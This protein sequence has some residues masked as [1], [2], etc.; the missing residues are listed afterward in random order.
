[1]KPAETSG[2]PAAP[3]IE[4]V[5]FV[6]ALAIYAA[7]RFAGLTR[8][9]IYFFCDEA[10]QGNLAWQRLHNGFRDHTGTFLPPYFL[11]DR[12]WAVS[13]SAYA[14]VLPALL[15]GKTVAAVRGPS[16]VV[17]ILGAAGAGVAGHIHMHALPR[18]V[19][20]A[21]F[22]SVIGETRVLPETLD[23]TWQR[24]R[25]AVAVGS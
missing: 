5:L 2:P 15:F 3:R 13:L 25:D 18:W 17:T 14:N 21:N 20:D 19:A 16:V 4:W 7:T 6:S 12:R 24:I 10:L 9:P 8:Y 23:V 11:N 1:M 22:V